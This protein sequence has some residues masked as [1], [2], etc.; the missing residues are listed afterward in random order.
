ME[1]ILRIE[2]K[3]V[4][5]IPNSIKRTIQI[6][7]LG[8]AEGRESS[9][10]QTVKLPKTSR[11]QR[12]FNFLGVSGN[13][14][15][16]PY[17][18]LSCDYVVDG[19]PLIIKGYTEV[20]STGSHYEVVIYDGV[21][22]IAEKLKG[23]TLG[24]LD[25]SDLNHYLSRANY[26]N[27]FDNTEGYIYALGRF[28][29]EEYISG[30]RAERQVPSVYTHTLWDKIFS[31]LDV[32]YT[33][34]F[35][36]NNTDFRSEVVTPPQGYE[37]EDI[38][39]T[40]NS[41]G[42]YDTDTAS[43]LEN[44][45][46]PIFTIFNT[47]GFDTTFNDS[48]V[49]F[50]SNGVITFNQT[51]STEILI[52]TTY[53]VATTGY[54]T[55]RAVLNDITIKSE[56]LNHGES[57]VSLLVNLSVEAGDEFYITTTANDTGFVSGP[58]ETEIEDGSSNITYNVNY[59]VEASVSISVVT[60]GFLV[61]F[62]KMMGDLPQVDFIKDVMQR[63][64]LIFRPAKNTDGYEFIQFMD[65]L[66]DKNNAEDWSDKLDGV[67]KEKYGVPYAKENKA[68][69]SYHE[70]IVIPTHDGSL[71]LDNENLEAEKSLFD[72]PYEIPTT[73]IKYRNE[74]MY[75]H[76]VWEKETEDGEEV[77]K[78]KDSPIKTFRIK[79][80]NKSFSA[81]YFNDANLINITDEI[82]YLTLEN[83]SMQYFLDTY[84]PAYKL[85]INRF[86]EIDVT[87]NLSLIDVHYLDLFKLKYLKQTGK[88]YYLNKIKHSAGGKLSSGVLIEINQ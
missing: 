70:D 28:I 4:D 47:L 50:G 10:S 23:K 1:E 76:P 52:D 57:S 16:S 24:S 21:I 81:Q 85:V 26:L 64:G 13:M 38:T 56:V 18:K 45:D 6:N 19:I 55:I 40:V 87:L 79:R 42:S 67:S 72:S 69:Y 61:D 88:Y 20:K 54:Y 78:V 30:I 41:I 77:I 60:G 2:N 86:K 31:E 71:L 74:T 35:F 73:G 3:Q 62:N 63:Y 11:N 58:T 36:E 82:P 39:P 65:L 44:S 8:S 46:T 83:M 59:T 15:D 22:D 14:S 66:T 37:V 27:S 7:D 9:Y 32:N 33:G 34:E 80:I 17:L 43:Y 29:D 84:Y 49:T 53:S 68:T 5:L 25:Y 48:R 75:L 51:M 12:V